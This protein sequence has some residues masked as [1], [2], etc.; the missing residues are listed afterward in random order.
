MSE[1]TIWT[2]DGCGDELVVSPAPHKGD[3]R[4]ITVTLDGFVGYPVGS[5][6]DGSRSYELCPKC[7]QRLFDEATPRKWPREIRREPTP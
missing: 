5:H 6:A 3:W 2:C 1:R 7:Q 4:R